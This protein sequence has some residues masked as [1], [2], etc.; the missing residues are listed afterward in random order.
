MAIFIVRSVWGSTPYTPPANQIFSDVPPGSFGYAEIQ[1][2]SALG[3]TN[4]CAVG[5][6]CPNENITREQMAV[7][8][9][10]ARLGAGLPFEFPS[11]PYFTDV[12]AGA[13]A[14]DQIQ[15]M[16]QDNIT[17][18]CTPTT[19]CP[20]EDV[21]RGDMAIFIMRGEFNQ[22]LPSGTALIT[23][24]SPNTLAAGQGATL[25]ITGVNTSFQQGL[26]LVNPIPGVTFSVPTVTSPTSMTVQAVVS[27]S[28]TAQP[29]P[30][31]V[32]TGT[33]NAVL[34]NGFVVQ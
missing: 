30:I 28:P 21:T 25:T 4:G 16:R 2:L 6:F 26:S 18:G 3:I 19:F 7:F 15:R 10:S 20:T 23:S 33:Q 27:D 17:S 31:E 22:L 9:I 12:P 5:M 29:W 1:E 32:I 8:I 11:T 24:V 13:F 34:P 14:F